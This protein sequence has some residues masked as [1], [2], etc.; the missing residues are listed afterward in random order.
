VGE[1]GVAG[2]E[3]VEA[4]LD[5]EVPDLSELLNEFGVQIDDRGFGKFEMQAARVQAALFQCFEH[6]RRQA[7]GL[8]LARGEVDGD[9]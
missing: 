8:E 3:V 5:A 2:S 7:A 6:Q 1:R 9:R 4:E